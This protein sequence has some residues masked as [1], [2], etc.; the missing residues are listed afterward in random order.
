MMFGGAYVVDD[1]AL[2]AQGASSSS[3]PTSR[4]CSSVDY[5]N[6]GDYYK[7]EFYFLLLVSTF[8]HEHHGV[9]TRPH[10]A[11][12]RA[13]DDLDPDVR[14]RRVP[15][16]RPEVER[17]G[18]E[19]LPDRCAV[20]GAHALRHVADLRRHRH[21]RRSTAISSYVVDSGTA[22]AARR[23][24][25]SCRSSGSRSRS[26]RCRSTSGR[27]TPTKV[28]P[29][30]SPRSSRSSSKAGG[31]V[32]LINIIYFGFYGRRS[33]RATHGGRCGLGARRRCR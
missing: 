8:G 16:A 17:G 12:R 7:G 11:V 15:Q 24:R 2:G 20:V 28:R 25:S 9:G 19:V 33:R 31:F 22:A 6:E 4:S 10:H 26:A 29:R 21:R 32:A 18:R 3:R 14:A 5:I 30:R 1:Y 23:S 13:R 27:P